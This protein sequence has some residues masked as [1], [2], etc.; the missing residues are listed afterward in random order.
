MNRK[1]AR[2][3][4]FRNRSLLH[5]MGD[6]WE[7]RVRTQGAPW[8]EGCDTWEKMYFENEYTKLI[9]DLKLENRLL[10]HLLRCEAC[11]VNI[12]SWWKEMRGH[13]RID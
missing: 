4:N 10:K 5:G 2:T 3:I 9:T 13:T 6:L 8:A 1:E 11:I 12:R 7:L